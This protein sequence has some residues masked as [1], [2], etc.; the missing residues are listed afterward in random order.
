MR[1]SVALKRSSTSPSTGR[2]IH[3]ERPRSPCDHLADPVKVLHVQR[4]VEPE[5]GAEA[6]EIF[7]VGV[8]A[9]HHLGGV[10]RRQMQHHEHDH[11]HPEQ[12]G[13]QMQEPAREEA[14]PRRGRAVR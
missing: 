3:S 5:L 1:R 4:L 8:G 10:A 9:Q 6:V 13:S 12:H 11:R 14:D 2:F 7:L